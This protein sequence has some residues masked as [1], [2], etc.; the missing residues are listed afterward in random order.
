MFSFSRA[1]Q[2]VLKNKISNV[3]CSSTVTPARR[4][5]RAFV[6]ILGALV[7]SVPL[8][9]VTAPL[10]QATDTTSQTGLD[11]SLIS[12]DGH[13][14]LPVRTPDPALYHQLK[15]NANA[16][17][18]PGPLAPAKSTGPTIRLNK[19][20]VNYP[21]LSPSDSNGAI[22]TTRYLESTNDQVG[23]YRTDL[24]LISQF[25]ISALAQSTDTYA[26][27][28]DVTWDAQT[29]KFYFTAI[30]ENTSQGFTLHLGYSKS[31]SPSSAADFCV[32]HFLTGTTIPDYPK[33]GGT[34]N[35]SLVGVNNY[36]PTG[37]TGSSVYWL[38][39]P[40]STALT[41][42]PTL[43]DGRQDGFQFSTVPAQQTDPNPTGYLLSSTWS[44]GSTIQQYT[45]T[46]TDTPAFAPAG[47]YSVSAYSVPANAPQSNGRDLETLDNRIWQV[48]QA[49]DPRLAKTVLW[50]SLTTFG[51]PGAAVEWFELT[52]DNVTPA[53]QGVV[54]DPSLFAFNGSISSDRRYVSPTD[55][56][57]GSAMVVG[58]TTASASSDPAIRMVSKVGAASQS[59]FTLVI[60]SSG[61]DLDYTCPNVGNTCR[62]GDYSSMKASP[63]SSPHAA[64]GRVYGTNMWDSGVQST[65]SAHWL[66]QNWETIP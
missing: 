60:Q 45:V 59:G 15:A 14:I 58:F 44:G 43:P 28:P 34:T 50:S 25:S 54:S 13:A 20:G 7:L 16:R 42:C 32:Q 63:N 37:Y 64:T 66:T 23:I 26:S 30:T 17:R 53:Q 1:Q 2:T 33:I 39:K 65:S 21:Y 29:N 3:P 36:A 38:K 49:F 19:Q 56:S 10:G 61:P 31:A 12:P 40:D 8:T 24:A 9:V 5:H 47:S 48:Q 35:F 51:G 52:P 46:G 41:S 6:S 27:D 18:H 11:N 62:W 4:Q 57:F 22:G 55:N